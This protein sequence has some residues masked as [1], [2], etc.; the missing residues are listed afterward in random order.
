MKDQFRSAITAT[1]FTIGVLS[2]TLAHSAD[3]ALQSLGDEFSLIPSE[4]CAVA[5]KSPPDSILKRRFKVVALTYHVHQLDVNGD[6][7]CDWLREGFE[8]NVRDL[9]PENSIRL[10]KFL[11]LGTA[12]GWR[13][14]KP[15]PANRRILV[16]GEERVL[17]LVRVRVSPFG[18]LEDSHHPPSQNRIRKY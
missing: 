8:E 4:P 7:I 5:P 9:E 6:G 2:A 18:V 12:T 14:L 15:L 3:T 16:A 17:N 10:D 1:L 11:F 13:T